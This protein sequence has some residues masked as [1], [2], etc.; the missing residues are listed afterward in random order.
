M[1]RCE[2]SVEN[3]KQIIPRDHIEKGKVGA[4]QHSG[5]MFTLSISAG[6]RA[7]PRLIYHF[8]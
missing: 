3:E 8:N 5:S 1:A 7:D 6:R 2:W 4:A